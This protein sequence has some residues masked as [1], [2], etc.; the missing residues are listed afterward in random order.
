[1]MHDFGVSRRRT[2]ILDLP[3]SL[4]P[5]NQV[6]GMPSLCYDSTQPARFGVFPR[7]D[8]ARVEWFVTNPCLIFHTANT[9]DAVR[10][11]T[12]LHPP[13][14][15]VHM[16]ACR[17]TSVSMVFLAGNLPTPAF[18][19]VPPA[20]VEEEQCRLY[21]YAFA[22]SEPDHTSGG[23]PGGILHQW[24]LS[25]IPFEFPTLAP[26]YSMREARYVYG[27]STSESFTVALGKASKVDYLAKVDV[28]TLIA[29]GTANP[30]QPIKG[31]VD[32][33]TVQQVAKSSGEDPDDPIKLFKMPAGWYAQEPRFV[34]RANPA[35][36]DDGWLLSYV[37]DES[38]LDDR[39]DCRADA[40]SELWI[41]DARGM[42]DVVAR[43]KLP[44]RV[45]YGLHGDWFTEENIQ[46]QRPFE[47]V[48]DLGPEEDEQTSLWTGVRD[49]VEQW[50]R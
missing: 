49:M 28:L 14:A 47:R 9:W 20:Y 21:Y 16:L 19:P 45:P 1:M 7:Y 8:P 11:A 36:E 35:A 25:A 23:R 42:K 39:G 10:P 13:Q 12:K 27:C 38:Q 33:R 37:F 15:L 29:R 5:L 34:P 44:Q 31:C 50:L 4:D 43:V 24:A 3:L 6:R 32:T 41:I 17:L 26:G 40:R 48:R 22:L 2:V 18:K 30:P 46:H